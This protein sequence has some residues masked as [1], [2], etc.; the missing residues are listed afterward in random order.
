MGRMGVAGERGAETEVW[1]D[2]CV[3]FGRKSS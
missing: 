3:H 2:G 1:F